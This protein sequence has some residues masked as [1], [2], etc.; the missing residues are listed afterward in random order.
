VEDIEAIRAR[1]QDD[2]PSV[3]LAQ[4]PSSRSYAATSMHDPLGNVF[5]LSPASMDN[6]KS[7]HLELSD[8]RRGTRRISHLFLRTVDPER[9]A[10]FYVD[11]FELQE[12]EKE[13]GDPNYYLTDGTVT[14]VVAPW[15]I[16]NYT[17]GGIERPALDHLG[18]EV[19]SLEA[20][21]ADLERLAASNPSL[22]PMPTAG[23]AE[24]EV[25]MKLLATCKLGAY[26]LADPDGVLLDVSEYR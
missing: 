9:V 7:I 19:E 25:R 8:D 15:S 4:R 11:V 24:R 21:Q 13:A 12:R 20:F 2:Y 10:R 16:N 23:R 26:H 18:F 1:V 22:A 6:R 14:L 17:G 3:E 5:D